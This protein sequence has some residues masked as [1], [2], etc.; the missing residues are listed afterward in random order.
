MK[1]PLVVLGSNFFSCGWYTLTS[2]WQPHMCI[3]FKL[4]FH[5][6]HNSKGV[7]G[8][9]LDGTLF[10][11]YTAIYK[12]SLHMLEGRLDKLIMLL[13]MSINVRFL[14]SAT[15]FCCGEPGIVYWAIILFSSRNLA[16]GSG[17]WSFMWTSHNIHHPYQTS[18]SWYSFQIISLLLP[19]KLWK[20]IVPQICHSEN[21]DTCILCSHL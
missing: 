4:G 12:A 1:Y 21:R 7:L 16:N 11:I 17:L 18:Q 9:A 15:P 20:H 8:T 13:T 5:P 10:K 2:T 14:L 19:Y 3:W 6:F